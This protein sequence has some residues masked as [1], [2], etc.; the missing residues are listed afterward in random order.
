MIFSTL[1]QGSQIFFHKKVKKKILR[2]DF[3]LIYIGFFLVL[4]PIFQ[5]YI[6]ICQIGISC[7]YR[8]SKSTVTATVYTHTIVALLLRR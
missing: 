2:D 7:P 3:F 6:F 1:T 8:R 4:Y 5:L